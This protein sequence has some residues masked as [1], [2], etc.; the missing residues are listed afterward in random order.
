MLDE[1]SSGT[2]AMESF[3]A[4]F[5]MHEQFGKSLVLPSV[6]EMTPRY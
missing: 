1:C 3:Q 2:Q 4:E 5:G 6:V